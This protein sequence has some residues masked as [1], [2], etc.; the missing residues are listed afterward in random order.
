MYHAITSPLQMPLAIVRTS[1]SPSPSPRHGALL[2]ANVV[3]IVDDRGAHRTLAHGWINTFM[4]SPASSRAKA[5][6]ISAKG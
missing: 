6:A 2:D 5:V 1:T 4:P 3:V